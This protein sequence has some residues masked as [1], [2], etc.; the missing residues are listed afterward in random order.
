MEAY[1]ALS[2]IC[3]KHW[4]AFNAIAGEYPNHDKSNRHKAP[5]AFDTWELVKDIVNTVDRDFVRPL[6]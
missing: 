2:L 1:E 6:F 4:E 3:S 5:E